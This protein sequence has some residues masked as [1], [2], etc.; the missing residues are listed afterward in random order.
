MLS[1]E[2]LR[3][4]LSAERLSAYARPEDTDEV[5]GVARY[6]WNLAL[7][8]ALQPALHTLEVTVRNRLFRISGRIVDQTTLR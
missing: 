8:S 1:I 2:G 4:A 3:S 6:L 5:D 7:C